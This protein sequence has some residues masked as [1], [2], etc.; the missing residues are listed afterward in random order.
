MLEMLQGRV[1]VVASY[2]A[3]YV[4]RIFF[5]NNECRVGEVHAM[6]RVL[7][8][9]FRSLGFRIRTKPLALIR[10]KKKSGVTILFVDCE[11]F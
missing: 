7:F 9:D 5:V 3:H 4:C 11:A 10:R 8:C 1:A 6:M 2:V